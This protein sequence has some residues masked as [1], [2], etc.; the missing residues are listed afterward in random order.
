LPQ[1]KLHHI[2]RYK[3][4]P[5]YEAGRMSRIN[6][7][8]SLEAQK[9]AATGFT[10]SYKYTLTIKLRLSGLVSPSQTAETAPD[11]VW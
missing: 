10:Q 2:T 1:K 6:I 5:L 7:I 3:R 9:T 8:L 11:K 4:V